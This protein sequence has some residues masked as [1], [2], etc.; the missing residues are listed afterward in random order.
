MCFY[1]HVIC[2]IVVFSVITFIT[3]F[4][5]ETNTKITYI[6]FS[7][8]LKCHILLI[9]HS[10]NKLFSLL[11]AFY[12]SSKVITV[13]SIRLIISLVL[14]AD[15]GIF[16]GAHIVIDPFPFGAPPASR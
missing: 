15:Q 10:K 4:F 8:D 3:V 7:A 16:N 6:L 12:D 2:N 9:L 1:I 13:T 5:I 11:K 14:G